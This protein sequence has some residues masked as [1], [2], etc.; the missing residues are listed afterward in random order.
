MS[1]TQ[2]RNG[3]NKNEG[4]G[5]GKRHA[6]KRTAARV[7]V[8]I[9]ALLQQGKTFQS[10]IVRDLSTSGAGLCG[11][12]GVL[13][14]DKVSIQ[15]LDGRLISGEVRWWFAGNCGISFDEELSANDP[16]FRKVRTDRS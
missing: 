7:P 6:L 2:Y 11:A 16:L 9:R 10:T 4:D 8:R 5:V 13:P 3:G 1:D 14:G 15:F 12:T